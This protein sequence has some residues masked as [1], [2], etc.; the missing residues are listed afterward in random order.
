MP[1]VKVEMRKGKS[2]AYKKALLDAI[3]QALVDIFKTP[4]DNRI[5]RLYE[6]EAA[7]FKI[8]A[9]KTED[10]LLIE[11]TVFEGRNLA[12]KSILYKAIVDNLEHALGIKR[13]DI[14]IVLNETPRENWGVRGGVPASVA[15][16]G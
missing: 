14:L 7:N 8:A 13:T 9:D 16:F 2:A 1:L 4:E 15:S 12:T 6:L 11:L 3:H 5:Q 10:F